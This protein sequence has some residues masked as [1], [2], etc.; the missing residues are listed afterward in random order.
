[1]EDPP[2]LIIASNF[3]NHF[4]SD[5]LSN[6]FSS[7]F[8]EYNHHQHLLLHQKSSNQLGFMELL[9]LQDFTTST[10][11]T[12]TST[13]NNPC[14][15]YDM[16]MSSSSA[17]EIPLVPLTDQ[18][19]TT[20][21]SSTLVQQQNTPGESSEMVFNYNTPATPNSSSIS[22]A[23][24]NGTAATAPT[25]TTDNLDPHHPVITDIAP[26]LLDEDDDDQQK[27]QK[28]LKVKKGGVGD[29]KKK[30]KKEREP[31][32]AFMTKSEVDQLEDGYRWRKYGQKAVKNSPFP[33]SYY[34]CTSASCNVKKRVERCFNDPSIVV[35]TYEGQHIH[36]SPTSIHRPVLLPHSGFDFPAVGM[37]PQYFHNSAPVPPPM[38]YGGGNYHL[39]NS[40]GFC[41]GASPAAA[42][43]TDHGLLQDIVPSA[44]DHVTKE[45]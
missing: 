4:S 5:V 22:S 23:S 3:P 32:V 39:I 29:M 7:D 11:T 44:I 34:R 25:T 17:M 38:N 35:T 40:N 9:G 2:P 33:R 36:P 14:S 12:S 18:T 28:Q 8:G 31:R 19:T 10:S 16:F 6:P 27:T 26:P 15:F 21:T 42:L 24:S 13:I 43:L 45:E 20:T 1:M 37:T 41:N 30:K